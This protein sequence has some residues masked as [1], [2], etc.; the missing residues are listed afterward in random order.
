MTFYI[1]EAYIADVD[2][3]WQL[4]VSEMGYDFPIADTS[5]RLADILN[6]SHDKIFVA[7]CDGT[8]AGYVHANDYN[9]I[10]AEHM[11]NIMGIAVFEK[12]KRQG[13]GKALLGK[14]EEWARSD[15]AVGIRLVSG[16]N[17]KQAH[18]FYHKCGYS[19][20]KNQLNLSKMF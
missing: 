13:I 8:V 18:S 11:K 1:R 5:K 14:V 6:S 7:I 12:F 20:D 4:N 9:L 19:N 2:A 15:N 16:Q 3:I 17:R 10:Y